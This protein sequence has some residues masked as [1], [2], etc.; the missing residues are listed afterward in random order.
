M[1]EL[2]DLYLSLDGKD[3]LNGLDLK[4]EWGEITG[5]IGPP[6]SGKTVLLRALCGRIKRHAGEIILSENGWPDNKNT[7][8]SLHD[9]A[10]P[11]NQDITLEEYLILSRIP[12]KKLFRSFDDTDRQ[13]ASEY[14]GA[15][16]LVPYTGI[17]IGKLTDSTFKKA[18]LAY[19]FIKKSPCLLLDDPTTGLD[20]C[21][22]VSLR[23]EISRY[24]IDGGRS[25]I[26]CSHDL[27]FTAR[28]ADRIIVLDGGR[29]C[30]DIEPAE[31]D[32]GLIKKHFGLEVIISRNVLNG[33]PEIHPFY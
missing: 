26:F 2:R 9:Y 19:S 1:I 18:L 27:N 4:L 16:G 33:R 32:A 7:A 21:S 28:T 17:E 11:E 22:C 24:V 13:S 15:F 5:I 23:K 20:V 12:Y 30:A 25:V 6:G 14:A 29:V 3:V 10:S 31:L 8:F